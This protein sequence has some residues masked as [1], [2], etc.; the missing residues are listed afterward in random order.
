[1]DQIEIERRLVTDEDMTAYALN[2]VCYGGCGKTITLWW[3]G[4]ELDYKQCCGYTYS[5]AHGD[6]YFVVQQ[7]Q[8]AP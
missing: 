8:P 7:K 5:L 4:G 6:I 3:N 1:M 2:V